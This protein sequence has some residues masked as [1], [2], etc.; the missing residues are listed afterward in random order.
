MQPVPL[1]V[2]NEAELTNLSALKGGV[3]GGGSAETKKG[4]KGR[5]GKKETG[6]RKGEGKFQD[7]RFKITLLS[8]QRN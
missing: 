6:E 4:E 8:H 7:S 3:G 5:K 1:I 2:V